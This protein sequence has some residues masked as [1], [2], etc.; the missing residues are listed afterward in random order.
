VTT[1]TY[2]TI[3]KIVNNCHQDPFEILGS[4]HIEKDNQSLWVVRAYL[5]KADAVWVVRP[6]EREEHPMQAV[7]DPHF[8]EC[9]LDVPELKNYQLKIQERDRFNRIS[10][11][12]HTIFYGLRTEPDDDSPMQVAMVVNM[13]GNPMKI[14]LG[15]WLKLDL[16][17]WEIAI[18]SP[19]VAIDNLHSFELSD[20]QGVLLVS[21]S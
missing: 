21:Q 2:Q 17:E 5:P 3:E 9:Q 7:G 19:G 20:S 13:G 16:D 15:D 8:F 11:D 12:D 14:T 1:L 4:H 10:D 18:A 6:Q